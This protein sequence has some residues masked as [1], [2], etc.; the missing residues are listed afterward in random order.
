MNHFYNLILSKLT[1]KLDLIA[2][3]YPFHM[4]ITFEKCHSFNL[5]GNKIFWHLGFIIEKSDGVLR[6]GPRLRCAKKS[7]TIN[8]ARFTATGIRFGHAVTSSRAHTLNYYVKTT[9]RGNDQLHISSTWG[10]RTRLISRK[11]AKIIDLK[12]D[13]L[14]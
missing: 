7:W 2:L 11:F 8:W 13:S 5:S 6:K 14:S 3:M 10:V 1:W 9:Y 12:F 4:S